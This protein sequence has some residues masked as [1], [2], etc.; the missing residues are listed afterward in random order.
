MVTN[1]ASNHDLIPLP[2]LLK[3][4]YQF[5]MK[6]LKQAKKLRRLVDA[7][8]TVTSTIEKQLHAT[9]STLTEEFMNCVTEY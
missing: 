5:T 2:C 7:D 8:P 1:C 9:Y 4:T 6:K 3:Q